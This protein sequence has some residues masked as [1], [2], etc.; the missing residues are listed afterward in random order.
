MEGVPDGL[1]ELFFK[2]GKKKGFSEEFLSEIL[3]FFVR[4]Q[5]LQQGDREHIRN[6]LRRI[7]EKG[8]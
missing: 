3:G 4:N 5:Y 1:K 2:L 6:N 8:E 7:I